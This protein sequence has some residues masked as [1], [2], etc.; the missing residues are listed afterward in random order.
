MPAAA[1]SHPTVTEPVTT[2]QAA[3]W[4]GISTAAV[5]QRLRRGRLAGWKQR[6]RWQVLIATGPVPDAADGATAR[7]DACD[8]GD[9]AR[10]AARTTASILAFLRQRLQERTATARRPLR[11][12][13]WPWRRA[14][15]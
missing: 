7:S 3:R 6:G 15:E 5:R 1:P 4:L 13:P 12:W 8:W 9:D 14:S 2:A 10:Q 11:R